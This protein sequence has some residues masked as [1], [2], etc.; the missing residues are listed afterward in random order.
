MALLE[1]ETFPR[2]KYCG[3]PARGLLTLRTGLTPNF[4]FV[5]AGDAVCTPAI[6]IL[7]EMGVM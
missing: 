1:K 5:C 4:A 7:T 3:A 6:R 2:D